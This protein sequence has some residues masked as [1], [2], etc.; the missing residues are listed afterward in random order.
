MGMSSGRRPGTLG[1]VGNSLGA[2]GSSEGLNSGADGV[3]KGENSL[4][5]GLNM[6]VLFGRGTYDGLMKSASLSCSG[7]VQTDTIR[8][9]QPVR[10]G[11][12]SRLLC[13]PPRTLGLD[14]DR[15]ILC[16]GR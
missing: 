6:G 7:L 1:P 8:G 16:C 15:N 3:Y 14:K 12:K 10:S 4:S 5:G 2:S 13:L 11:F 9:R